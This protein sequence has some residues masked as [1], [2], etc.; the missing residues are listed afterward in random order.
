MIDISKFRNLNTKDTR[1][2]RQQQRMASQ[3][4]QR[5]NVENTIKEALTNIATSSNSFVIYGEPQ[6]GKTEMMISLTAAL[7]DKGHKII[8]ILLN[9]NLQL[10]QQN[11]ERFVS[12]G[13][14]PAPIDISGILDENIGNKTWIIFCK[15][16]I[17]DLDRLIDKVKGKPNKIVID[18]EADFASPNAKINR[19]QRTAINNAIYKLLNADGIYVGV[20]AT[21][22]RLDMNNTFDNMTEYWICFTPHAN[23]VGKEV[24]FPIDFKPQEHSINFLP[25][26]G[27]YPVHLRQALLSFFVNVAYINLFDTTLRDHLKFHGQDN[28]HFTF[29]IHTSGKTADHKIDEQIANELIDGLSNDTSTHFENYV[30]YMHLNASNKYGSDK[31]D[32]IVIFVLRNIRRKVTQVLNAESKLRR[33]TLLNLTDPP[34]LFTVVIGGNIISRGIT[35]NNLIGMFFTRDVKHKMQQDTYIQRA[36][37]FGNRGTYLKYFELFIPEQLYLDWHRCFVYHQLSLEA[38]KA[39]K[40]AP[41]WISDDRIRPVASGSIDKR[42]VVTDA[43]EMYFAKFTF[44]D[45]IS[46]VLNDPQLAELDQLQKIHDIYGDKILPPYVISFIQINSYPG[47]IAIHPI[48]QVGKETDYHDTLYRPRG[49]LG[50]MD[51]NRHPNS[52]H[53]FMIIRNTKNECRIVYRYAGKVQFLRNFRGKLN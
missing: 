4:L 38:I 8:I 11:L 44:N 18:D 20:T 34:S 30:R 10:L 31:A 16:N 47:N 13:I 23:Y 35:F 6:C 49:V 17:K 48:R 21:P 9:D 32:D 40:K 14:D 43:G 27:D 1:Y 2:E 39:D 25:P 50:G 15:K 22:A 37:M 19:D 52:V 7:L 53:H 41:V 29:L 5:D 46:K 45:E 33:R 3:G 51:I 28:S 36:R 26:T 12:S 24:F 42:S